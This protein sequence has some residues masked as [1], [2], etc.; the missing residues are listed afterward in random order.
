MRRSA[1]QLRHVTLFSPQRVRFQSQP[2]RPIPSLSL[3]VLAQDATRELYI[4]PPSGVRQSWS[5]AFIVGSCCMT[6]V[7]TRYSSGATP[8]I[9]KRSSLASMF[10]CAALSRYPW[11]PGV[12][13][14]LHCLCRLRRFRGG[15]MDGPGGSSSKIPLPQLPGGE[16]HY[17]SRQVPFSSPRLDTQRAG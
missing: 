11:L 9:E 4:R 2:F 12:T 8:S 16:P 7:V 13:P 5:P 14:V 15:R 6:G 1:P 3:C 10:P 17:G